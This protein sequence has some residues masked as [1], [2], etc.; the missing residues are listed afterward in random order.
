[1]EG[2]QF[3]WVALEELHVLRQ[4]REPV[5]DDPASD[6]TIERVRLVVGEVHA[7]L[8]VQQLHDPGE[9]RRPAGL[10]RGRG[11]HVRVPSDARDLPRDLVRRKDEVD[12]ARGD[13]AARHARVLRRLILRERDA[14]S[15]FDRLQPQSAIGRAPREDHPDRLVRLIIRQG[16]EESIDGARLSMRLAR[17]QM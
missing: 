4:A 8:P 2:R 15:G 1:M 13:G 7:G 11:L 3:R 9:R 12:A 6:A 10:Y 16:L 5:E 14:A 17:Q